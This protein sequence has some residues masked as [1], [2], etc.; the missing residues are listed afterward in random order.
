MI[1]FACP[2]YDRC[3][4]WKLGGQCDMCG[5]C[6][7][8]G[9]NKNMTMANMDQS[10]REQGFQVT[11]K[12]RTKEGVY[13]YEIWKDGIYARADFKYDNGVSPGDRD[14]QQREFI[15]SLINAYDQKCVIKNARPGSSKA[16]KP[17]DISQNTLKI[18]KVHFSG[19]VTV[20]L[21]EDGT[22]TTVRCQEGDIFDPEK[23]LAMAIAKKALGNTCKWYDEF[24][25]W[26]DTYERPVQEFEFIFEPIPKLSF[27]W[28]KNP[29][30]FTAKE[31]SLN[32]EPFDIPDG[33][34][35]SFTTE[36][37]K[38][39]EKEEKTEEKP[40]EV[41]H[42]TNYDP[43]AEAYHLAKDILDGK[44]DNTFLDDLLGFIAEALE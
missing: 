27:D 38:T 31:G 3:D 43:V 10:F 8:K 29:L 1:N 22:K 35:L 16:I 19:P 18:K 14:R 23:G 28:L 33:V 37:E 30:T 13:A 42:V 7:L 9:E 20:V 2:E 44:K 5:N 32:L 4:H 6:N 25:K 36:S 40:E 17:I 12:Y 21:W 34:T 39:D 24:H 41:P 26:A 11:R 15:A